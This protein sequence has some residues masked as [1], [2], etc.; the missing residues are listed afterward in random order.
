MK[1]IRL[2]LV[3]DHKIII[4]GIRAM[5]DGAEDVSVVDDAES[6]DEALAKLEAHPEIN[7]VLLDIKMPNRNGIETARDIRDRFPT[8][9]VLALTMYDEEEYISSML[10]AG[11]KGYILKNTGKQELLDALRKVVKGEL[12]FSREVTAT[13]MQR[14]MPGN[15]STTNGANRNGAKSH[16]N[17]QDLTRREL[18]ILQLI[19]S[20]MTNP[21]IAEKLFISPRTVHSHRRNLMQKLGVKNTAG[22]VRFALQND[23]LEVM[24]HK[25]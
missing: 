24:K 4:N 6:G 17:L 9:L 19:A 10:Q 23:I 18:E 13:V 12:Y 20:E 25:S 11:A 5:L 7:F 21:E 2:L 22:L 3:D 15:N 8:V 1:P 16:V 14:F